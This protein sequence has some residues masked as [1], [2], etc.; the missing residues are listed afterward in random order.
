MRPIGE[1]Y[2]IK[3]E[4]AAETN[5]GG[6]IVLNDIDITKDAFWNGTIIGYGTKMNLDD[7]DLVP[8]G[9]KVVINFDRKNA[10]KV[11]IKKKVI[12]SVQKE[13]VIATMED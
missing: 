12:Y 8:I 7:P 5:E 9:T 11:I 3:C 10:V 13:D 6:I 2:L 1:T 4:A